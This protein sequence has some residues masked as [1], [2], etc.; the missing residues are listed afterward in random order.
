[1]SVVVMEFVMHTLLWWMTSTPIGPVWAA[2]GD[3]VSLDQV[4]FLQVCIS[5]SKTNGENRWHTLFGQSSCN[6][7][8]LDRAMTASN[9]RNSSQGCTHIRVGRVDRCVRR[10]L[11]SGVAPR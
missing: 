5:R 10:S 3:V 9:L 8:F 6:H 7:P 4:A 11:R 2:N 1:L